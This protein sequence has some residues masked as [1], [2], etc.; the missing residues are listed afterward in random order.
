MTVWI[1]TIFVLGYLLIAG[2]HLTRINK[3]AVALLTAVLC[4]TVYIVWGPE[5]KPEVVARLV[6]HLGDVA[7]VLFFV[8]GAMTIV[9]LID[10]HEGFLVITNR[11]RRTNKRQLLWIVAWLAFFLSS[12]LDNLTTTIVAISLLRKLIAEDEDRR[13]YAGLVIIAANAGGA[14]TPIGDVTTT[15]L[16]IGGQ[17]TTKGII[18]SIGMPSVVCLVVATA[19][20]SLRLKGEM[21][22]PAVV[23]PAT[24]E[25]V[26]RGHQTAI[27]VFGLLAL[28]S[29][30]VFKTV[31][32]LPPFMGMLAALGVMWAIVEILHR[33]KDEAERHAYSVVGALRRIDTTVI[34]FF[35]GILLCVAALQ[36]VGLLSQLGAWMAT[37][38][39]DDRLI[40]VS[41]GILSAVIDN[42]PLTAAAQ[43]MYTLAQYP[44]DHEFWTLLAYCVGTG[45]SALVIGSAAGVAAMGMERLDFWWYLRKMTWIALCAYLAGV[46]AFI[47]QSALIAR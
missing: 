5:T 47:V 12:V 14:W 28:A 38:M 41:L 1:V 21:A 8:L 29:V 39:G 42:V 6:A 35:L 40:V 4:W 23:V 36:S 33:D 7:G 30:P 34:L 31:T 3:A 43:G 37:H 17:I 16:W 46:L 18:L 24:V 9:E 26:A 13:L 11:I 25:P 20:V 15:M 27:L 45:G 44:V 32:H 19:L 2:E 10:A 22:R